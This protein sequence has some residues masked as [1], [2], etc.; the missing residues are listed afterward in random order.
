MRISGLLREPLFP[1]IKKHFISCLNIFESN[2]LKDLNNQKSSS[3][4][5]QFL[6]LIRKQGGRCF[7]QN[8][9]LYFG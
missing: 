4:K 7:I 2:L 6:I 9:T 3:V 5:K 1:E 8:I